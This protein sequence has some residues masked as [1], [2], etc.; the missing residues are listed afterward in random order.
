MARKTT[1][2]GPIR[3]GEVAVEVRV[4]TDTDCTPLAER[5]Y[6]RYLVAKSKDGTSEG[7]AFTLTLHPLSE[8]VEVEA[9]EGGGE[10]RLYRIISGGCRLYVDAARSHHLGNG[11]DTSL[12]RLEDFGNAILA[13]VAESRRRGLF[14]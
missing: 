4:D 5:Q 1:D 8:R 9:L 6:A 7:D 10:V 12:D 14:Q 2:P 11:W 13:V 3:G